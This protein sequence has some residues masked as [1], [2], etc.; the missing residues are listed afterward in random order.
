MSSRRLAVGPD[1]PRRLGPNSP[2]SPRASVPVDLQPRPSRQSLAITPDS[3]LQGRR[4]RGSRGSAAPSPPLARA[5][6]GERP[7]RKRGRGCS[8]NWMRPAPTPQ[9][10]RC[11]SFPSLEGFR[12]A[13][14]RARYRFDL[15]TT[16]LP[17][18][19]ETT[20]KNG[21]QIEQVHFRGCWTH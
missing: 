10:L 11:L 3:P 2:R 18:V 8:G 6:R 12:G 13:S 20:F 1:S 15:R 19:E 9:L 4:H 7:R 5:G 17:K 16:N 21:S 14:L